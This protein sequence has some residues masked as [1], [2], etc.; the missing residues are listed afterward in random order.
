MSTPLKGDKITMPL[1]VN[2]KFIVSVDMVNFEYIGIRD[3]YTDEGYCNNFVFGDPT[4]A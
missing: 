1:T 3:D 4:H 2:I